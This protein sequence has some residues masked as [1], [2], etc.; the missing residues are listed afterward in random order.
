MNPLSSSLSAIVAD[1]LRRGIVDTSSSTAARR[2]ASGRSTRAEAMEALS[3][4]SNASLQR[5]GSSRKRDRSLS[6]TLTEMFHGGRRSRSGTLEEVP[7]E[8]EAVV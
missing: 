1:S 8:E 5:P 4:D 3:E 6:A 2:R 7:D